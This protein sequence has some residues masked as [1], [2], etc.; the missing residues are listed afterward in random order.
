M[1]FQ[2]V[3]AFKQDNADNT[4]EGQNAQL[5]GKVMMLSSYQREDLVVL[6]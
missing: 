1:K 6:D 3:S 5:K 2:L 4:F